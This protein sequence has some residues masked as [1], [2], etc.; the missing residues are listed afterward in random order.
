MPPP[1][2]NS[3]QGLNAR[4]VGGNDRLAAPIVAGS[5]VIIIGLMTG[6]G[7]EAK[8]VRFGVGRSPRQVPVARERAAR[9]VHE[10]GP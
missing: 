7:V 6:L 3:P 1:S 2:V 5:V 8:G 9:S 4:H 10:A